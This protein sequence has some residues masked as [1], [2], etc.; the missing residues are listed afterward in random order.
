VRLSLMAVLLLGACS[1]PGPSSMPDFGN[2]DLGNYYTPAG[3]TLV[4][5]LGDTARHDFPSADMVLTAGKDYRAVIETDAGRLVLDLHETDTPITVNSFVFL[6]LHHYYDNIAF[7]RVIDS[8]MA[9][10]G[11][12]NT[13]D[14]DSSSW[15]TGGPG[16]QYGLE[17]VASLKYDQAG[18][19]GSARSNSPN[20]NGSQF[21]I[22]FAAQ[23]SLDGKYTIFGRVVEGID[24]LP[25]IVRGEPPAAPTR[26]SR[27]YI[28]A[29]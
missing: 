10:G 26:M 3:Y 22:T 14:T 5:F 19:V 25:K 27:V 18:V 28:I 15:G 11:D 29:N 20:T 2:P 8:F 24:V 1:D 16:Y 9:Q 21:F 17:V 7:H 23:P 6:A 12:P 13:L 4:P